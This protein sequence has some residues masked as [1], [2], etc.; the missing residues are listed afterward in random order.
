MDARFIPFTVD[1]SYTDMF[2]NCRYDK[3][4]EGSVMTLYGP[5]KSEIGSIVLSDDGLTTQFQ[6]GSVTE[7]MLGVYVIKVTHYAQYTGL[8]LEVG[9]AGD[10]QAALGDKQD[11]EEEKDNA[12][13]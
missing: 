2:V 7:D 6:V 4:V 10:V 8:S 5:D 1:H 9:D 13:S 11:G 3:S 12:G